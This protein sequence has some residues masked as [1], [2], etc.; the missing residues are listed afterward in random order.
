[1]N[2]KD[3]L[4]RYRAMKRWIEREWRRLDRTGERPSQRYLRRSRLVDDIDPLTLRAFLRELRDLASPGG[5]RGRPT[6]K[7]TRRV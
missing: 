6:A 2:E 1:V 5:K 3:V 4:A 7:G